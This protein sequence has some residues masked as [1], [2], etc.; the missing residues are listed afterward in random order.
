MTLGLHDFTGLWSLRRRVENRMGQGGELDGEASFTANGSTLIYAE[1]GILKIGSA[2][3]AANQTHVW[4]ADANRIHVCFGDG[5]PF[6]SFEP[7]V[8]APAARHDCAPDVYNV[9]YD[10]ADWPVWRSHWV[11]T[12][13]RKDYEMRSEYAPSTDQRP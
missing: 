6:H 8:V 3:I 2:E 4:R 1:R 12:G 7:G 13:P 11:V 5:R 10:F 9:S